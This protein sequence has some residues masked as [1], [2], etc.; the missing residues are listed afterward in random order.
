MVSTGSED[1]VLGAALYGEQI[2]GV[3]DDWF[4]LPGGRPE[5][6][7]AVDFLGTRAEYG[8]ALELGVGTG[9]VALPLAARGTTVVGIDASPRMLAR[10]AAK[11]GGQDL[12]VVVGDFA[13]VTAPGGPF[14]LVYVVFNT[15]FM[16][17][18]QE[19][20]LRCFA[21]VAAALRPGGLFVLEAFVPDQT[22]YD[23]GQRVLVDSLTADAARLSLALHDP[24]EQR[25][26][27]RH[28]TLGP[29]GLRTYPIELRYA[30]PSELDLMGRLAGLELAERWGGW[31]GQ[32][33]TAASLTHVSV[34]RKPDPR[35]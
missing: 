21:N 10:L 20:Q 26:Q 28:L 5:G 1:A 30:W 27:V 35:R 32:P 31:S 4:S 22:R 25:V 15:F 19:T 7:A 2:A 14:S 18:D 29:E 13:D 9:R 24:V 3:Y 33:F 16:L 12:E 11:P 23:R 34:W 17:C 6:A 8:P